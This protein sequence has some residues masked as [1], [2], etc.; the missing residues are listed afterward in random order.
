MKWINFINLK[1]NKKIMKKLVFLFVSLFVMAIAAENVN[2]QNQATVDNAIANATI[3]TPI[4]LVNNL[5]FELGTLV[6]PLSGTGTLTIDATEALNRTLADGLTAIPGDLYRPAKFTVTGDDDQ[7]FA[8]TKPT[9]I[10][11]NGTTDD[12]TVTTSISGDVAGV[13]TS[14]GT[15]VFYIGGSMDVPS[16]ITSGSYSGIYEV[17]VA[18]E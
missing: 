15:Y 3:I 1:K 18:Y 11:L 12:L 7:S 13:T 4:T 9:T 8:I 10:T 2:A 14:T 16:D 6:K 5:T 17:S